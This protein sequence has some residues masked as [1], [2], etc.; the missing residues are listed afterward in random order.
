MSRKR[1]HNRPRQQARAVTTQMVTR[2][3][4]QS[5]SL[6]RFDAAQ[7]TTDNS[8]HWVNADSLGPNAAMSTSI[9]AIIRQRSRYEVANNS[10]ARGII[11][12]L[13]ND[14]IGRGPQLQIRTGDPI[15]DD[16]I[17]KEFKLWMKKAKLAT[18]LRLMRKVRAQDGEAFAVMTTNPNLAHP[19][20]L[21]LR[22][23]EADQ[24]TT[25][26]L[27]IRPTDEIDGIKFD[28]MG[29]A[30][31]YHVL[32]K[33]PG[34]TPG[35][36]FV[37]VANFSVIPAASMLHYFQQ[38]RP[39]QRRG[40]P[41]IMP[42]L[43]LFADLR[44]YTQ[45]VIASAETAADFAGVIYSDAPANELA[46]DVTPME[47]IE[48]EKRAMLSL[49]SGWKMNQMKAEQPTTT[50]E[51]FV[52]VIVNEIARCLS[53][54]FNVAYGNSSGYNYASGRLDHQTYFKNIEVERCVVELDILDR[55]LEAWIAEAILISDFL[56]LSVRT[57]RAIDH[58]WFW[59]GR[60]HVD[61][62]KEANAQ[63]TRLESNTTTLAHEFA[64]KGQDWEKQLRQR[65]K[66]NELIKELGLEKPVAAPVP[67]GSSGRQDRDEEDEDE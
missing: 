10:W 17:E 45:A 3:P 29:E 30:V 48:I 39:G 25:P 67:A 21:D 46:A 41:D 44:R 64:L 62:A 55:I 16:I 33:H 42:A 11:N 28:D 18:K 53:I 36:Q 57:M 38:D 19:V 8:R 14:L 12:T 34:E 1:K 56:P 50:H 2:R 51:N 54:P 63:K 47:T 65:A 15:A 49:P 7:T 43:S 66:E 60:E 4:R 26:V 58:E 35:V 32:G 59:P 22:L 20:K 27:S 24:V 9:R 6:A 37:A 5:M 23:V 40:L 61:P 31:E 13:A 52:Q